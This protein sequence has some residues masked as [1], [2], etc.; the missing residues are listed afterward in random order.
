MQRKTQKQKRKERLKKRADARAAANVKASKKIPSHQKVKAKLADRK[1]KAELRAAAESLGWQIE[2]DQE[3][4]DCAVS[5]PESSFFERASDGAVD[6]ASSEGL[7]DLEVE[8]EAGGDA[9]LALSSQQCDKVERGDITGPDDHT[10]SQ[11]SGIEH[12][13][14]GGSPVLIE[15]QRAQEPERQHEQSLE[16]A[17]TASVTHFTQGIGRLGSFLTEAAKS[18]VHMAESYRAFVLQHGAESFAV[19]GKE[20]SKDEVVREIENLIGRLTEL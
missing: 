16:Q 9:P 15:S 20:V 3:G 19:G 8:Q 10:R 17:L 5:F 4:E 2:G 1:V 13:L 18:P 7:G 12:A 14:D 11:T 6:A